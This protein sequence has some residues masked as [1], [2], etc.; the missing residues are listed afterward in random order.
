MT[1][2][3]KKM[4]TPD[5]EKTTAKPGL[6]STLMVVHDT[7][8]TYHRYQISHKSNNCITTLVFITKLFL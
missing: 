8:E 7:R 3:W 5:N 4:A 1:E 2:V 6:Q